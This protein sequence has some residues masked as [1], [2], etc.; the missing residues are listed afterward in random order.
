MRQRGHAVVVTLV[1]A[2][3]ACGTPPGS[4]SRTAEPG[5]E[6][7]RVFEQGDCNAAAPLL[8]EALVDAPRQ[9]RVH[10]ALA[11]C[12][13]HLDI[14]Q[15]AITEFQWVLAHASADTEEARVA[16]DWL[17]AVGVLRQRVEDAP[18]ASVPT[19][20]GPDVGRTTV[21]GQVAWGEGTAPVRTSHLQLFLQGRPGTPTEGF[22]YL[23]RTDGEGRFEFRQVPPGRYKLT[24]KLGK[25][26]I[27]RLGVDV[28]ADGTLSVPLTS[29]NSRA[30]RDDYP[31][32]DPSPP[33]SGGTTDPAGQAEPRQ[34]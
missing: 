33:R 18:A 1:L 22:Q 28:P 21:A 7:L 10:Y 2:A 17:T 23:A 3:T 12:A 25:K 8:R 19:S 13:S 34:Q 11:V 32:D 24:D 15:E 27:W 14:R 29:E 16:R 20:G 31:E 4:V 30:A 6:A 26:P 5:A 9:V